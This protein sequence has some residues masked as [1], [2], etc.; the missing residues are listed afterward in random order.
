MRKAFIPLFVPM[1]LCGGATGALVATSARAQ[2]E[3]REP[4]MAAVAD[5]DT[6]LAQNTSSRPTGPAIGGLPG[7]GD[8]AQR[9]RERCEDQYARAVGGMAYLETRLDL[10]S[11]QQP[12]FSAWRAVKLDIARRRAGDCTQHTVNLD[13]GNL[14]PIDWM[15]RREDALKK[16]LADLDAERPAFAVFYGALT[17]DQRN[18]LWA[19]RRDMMHRAMWRRRGMMGMV[20][21]GPAPMKERPPVAPQ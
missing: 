18:V 16:R 10:T 8:R 21:P 11:G 14:T 17:P 9:R 12:L 6:L 2:T 7:A 3:I 20:R 5:P 15:A 13:R 4:V 1:L 19:D